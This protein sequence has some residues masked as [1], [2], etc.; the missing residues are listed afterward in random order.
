MFTPENWRYHLV[1]RFGLPH[2]IADTG[3]MGLSHKYDHFCVAGEGFKEIFSE[4]GIPA[5]KMSATGIPNFDNFAA[6][7]G[8]NPI[9]E[10]GFV[11][12]A[13][14]ALRESYKYENRKAFIKKTRSLANGRPIIF[15]LHPNENYERANAEIKKIIPEATVYT[16]ININ[17]F[18]ARCNAMVTK[19]SSVIMVA[20]ALDKKVY[21]DLPEHQLMKL[22]PIQN[23][24]RSAERIAAICKTYL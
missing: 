14:S 15:K 4:R 10:E 23:G 6:E 19:Y 13:T 1:R 11:L 12:G 2:Y 16:D 5:S 3:M 20:L 17:Y 24:G 8:E 22:K 7:L 9:K 18:I 21:S